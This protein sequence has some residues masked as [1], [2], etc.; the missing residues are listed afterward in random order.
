MPAPPPFGRPRTTELRDVAKRC[1]GD[2]PDL[3]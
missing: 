3:S 1:G 2:L